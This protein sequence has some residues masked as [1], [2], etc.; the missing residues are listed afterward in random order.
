MTMRTPLGRV[1]NHGAAHDGVGHW[2]VER[3]TALALAPL[4]LW[5]LFSLLS[6]PHVDYIS[7]SAWVGSGWNPVWL[8]LLVLLSAWHSWLGIQMV[9][10]DYVPGFAAK[11]STLLLST[12]A[13]ALLALSGV[14]AVLRT[15]FRGVP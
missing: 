7:A 15:V 14:Y 4:V 11:T 2:I 9:V 12:F 13:H 10:E 3:V 5:L 6:L 1:L 8:S